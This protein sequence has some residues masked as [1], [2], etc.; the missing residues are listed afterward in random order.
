MSTRPFEGQTPAEAHRSIRRITLPNMHLPYRI[1]TVLG[2]EVMPLKTFTEYARAF[3]P[4]PFSGRMLDFVSGRYYLGLELPRKGHFQNLHNAILYRNDHAFPRVQRTSR[5]RVIEDAPE[6]LRALRTSWDPREEVILESEPNADQSHV[7]SEPPKTDERFE[8][9][10]EA[11]RLRIMGSSNQPGWVLFSDTDYPGWQTY[12][13]T[14][15]EKQT[16]PSFI[17]I[18]IYRANHAFR[19]IYLG[20]EWQEVWMVFRPKSFQ[21]GLLLSL[22]S[23]LMYSFWTYRRLRSFLSTA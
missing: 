16:H 8:W 14:S 19:A 2:Y 6:R 4:E 22:L 13:R 1:R 10:E 9:K 17:Q 18:P 11:N 20:S 3:T 23:L 12:V 15:G 21:I 5:H 7:F